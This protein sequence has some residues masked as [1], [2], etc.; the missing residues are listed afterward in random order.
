MFCMF[1][2]GYGARRVGGKMQKFLSIR[3][4]YRIRFGQQTLFLIEQKV[5]SIG[6][7]LPKMYRG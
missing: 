6:E 2:V 4:G 1:D 5:K 3:V 7:S